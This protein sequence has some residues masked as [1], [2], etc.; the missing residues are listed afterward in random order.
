MAIKWPLPERGRKLCRLFYYTSVIS[1]L[2]VVVGVA[3]AIRRRAAKIIL[4]LLLVSAVL[5]VVLETL[6]VLNPY[7]L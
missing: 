6:G 3:I 5:E 1:A 2:A 4:A 7:G